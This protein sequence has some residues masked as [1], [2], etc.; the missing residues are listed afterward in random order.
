MGHLERLVEAARSGAEERAADVP[1]AEL[2]TLADDRA[3]RRPFH[4]A[5]TAPGISVICEFKRR[6]P[7]A[8]ELAGNSADLAAVVASYE[9][10]GAAAVSVLT[11]PTGFGGSL[12]DLAVARTATSLPILQKDF[13]VTERQVLE[14][15]AYGADAVLLI[16]AA[17]SDAE[18]V[19]LYRYA[20]ALDLD[21]LVETHSREELERALELDPRILGINNRNLDDLSV[22]LD[23]TFELLPDIPAGMTVVSESGISTR[24]EIERLLESGIDAALIGESVL[25][26]GDPESKL[27]E[28]SV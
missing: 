27:R 20:R 23:T 26:S 19:A 10:G 3:E 24:A 11:E 8:G 17:L 1:E 4:E 22:D 18:L 21:C 2:V 15:A 12:D 14:A 7:S 6:S 25:A 9:A 13:L 28:L 5:L 16:V